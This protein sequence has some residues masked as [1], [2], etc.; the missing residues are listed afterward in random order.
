M[1]PPA[2]GAPF[3]VALRTTTWSPW[4]VG[5]PFPAWPPARPAVRQPTL[6]EVAAE[7]AR[8]VTSHWKPPGHGLVVRYVAEQAPAGVVGPG[9]AATV[10]RPRSAARSS[11]TV[12]A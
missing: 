12:R 9:V 5:V 1:L 4:V 10:D 6:Q 11:T 7:P 3:Q 2:G 8:T